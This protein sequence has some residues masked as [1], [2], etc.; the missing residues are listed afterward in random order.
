MANSKYPVMN[1]AAPD[2]AETFTL[3]KQRLLLVCEDKEVEDQEKIA[4][5]IHIGL[6]DEGLR[7]LN[8]SGLSAADQKIPTNL[9]QRF[10]T[11]LKVSVNSR[12]RRLSLIQYR[13]T[14]NE[15]LDEFVT[16]ARTQ[17]HMC[18]FTDAEMQERIIELVIA[19]PRMEAFRRD[20]L[21]KDTNLTLQDVLKE[22]RK[23]ETAA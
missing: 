2:V 6:G 22:R 14:E 3:F 8:A 13:Q 5:K 20:L 7:R 17:A 15:S 11:Q 1:W 16:R 23:H 18:E 9:W 19:G 12:I 4:R 21:G 10:E